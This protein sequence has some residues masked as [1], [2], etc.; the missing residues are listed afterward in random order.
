MATRGRRGLLWLLAGGALAL[1]AGRWVAGLY[2]D[3]AFFHALGADIVWRSRVG[4]SLTLAGGAFVVATLFAFANLYAVRQSIVSLVLPQKL[5]D[6][7]FAEAIPTARLTLIAAVLAVLV[8]IIFAALPH[9][10]AQAA[11]AWDVVLFGETEPYLNRDLGFYITWI[12]WERALLTRATGLFVAVTV[13]VVAF[14][15]STPSV[16][17]TETGLYVSTW[18]RR[19]VG[20]L[21]GIAVLLVGW[22][23]RI[24][25]YERLMDG[26]GVWGSA[27]AAGAFAAYDH[28]IALP[29]LAAASFLTIPVAAVLVWAMWRDLKRLAFALL[30]ALV[31]AGPVAGALLPL[32]ARDGLTTP[33]AR[34]REQPYFNTSALYTRRAYGVE[35]IALS[36]TASDASRLTLEELASF[37]P[38]WEPRAIARS[39]QFDRRTQAP[40]LTAWRGTPIGLEAIAL[41]SGPTDAP[42]APWMA[43]R[44]VA[45]PGATSGQL[46][47]SLGTLASPLRSVIVH[48]EA[49]RYVLLADSSGR[50]AAPSFNS[51][52]ERLM[53]AWDLQDPRLVFRDPPSPRPV[54]V[55]SLN[56]H[57][58]V[59]RLAPFL[60]PGPTIT[61]IVRE[62]SLYWVTELFVATMDYPLSEPI[63]PF[64]GEVQYARHA[65]TALVHAQTGR[66]WLVPVERPDGVMRSWLRRYP[67]LFT[68]LAAM[69]EWFRSERP[70]AVDVAVVQGSGLSKVGFA[71]DS[72]GRRQ[73][74]RATDSDLELD[75]A[76]PALYQL[77]ADGS[78]GFGYAMDIAAEGR[79]LGA[80]VARG[81]N[82]RRT[83]FLNVQGPRWKTVLEQLVRAA[84]VAGIGRGIPNSR[85]GRVQVIPTTAGVAYVQSFYEWP[86][87]GAPRLL[88]VSVVVGGRA[89]AGRT[90]AEALGVRQSATG[91]MPDAVFRARVTALYEAMQS[92]LRAGDWRAYGDAWA[93]LGELL[94]RRR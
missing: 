66:V 47:P 82:H 21:G 19:H 2:A 20:V 93:A 72:L 36:D 37:V 60:A 16:R 92:A 77:E 35:E 14:Y 59:L 4:Y 70:P 48:P 68:P 74:L 34:R 42:L 78:L 29:Y 85:R 1:L 12:P 38:T 52:L 44:F 89:Q 63:K 7:E 17:W 56:V 91:T 25:R 54:L 13:L 46:A 33:A 83:E 40:I 49:G 11:L 23:W 53:L 31:L 51:T 86:S 26:T 84:D 65:A 73:M 27:D 87:D 28:R 18:V 50:T 94:G 10:W 3:W 43:E 32:L 80:L 22:A 30:T 76:P 39:V 9:D 69:P 81:G 24:A 5:L 45:S 90:I 71:N 75:S 15:A 67:D 61:P 41:R 79:T 88:G 6:L 8:G 62:D 64:G 55:S 57:E 58:R